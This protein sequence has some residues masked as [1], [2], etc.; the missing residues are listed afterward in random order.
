MKIGITYNL[1]DEILP[2]AILDGESM[3]EFDSPKTIDALIGVFERNGYEAVR[4]GGGIGIIDKIK[5]ESVDFVFNISEGYNGRNRESHIPSMLEAMRIPY[6]GS[7]PLTLGISLDKA[8]S[9]A[10]LSQAGIPTPAYRVAVTVDD[11][12]AIENTL[13]WPVITK[14]AWDGSSKGIYRSSKASNASELKGNVKFLLDKYPVQPVL[15][16]EYIEGRE[17]TVGVIGNNPPRILGLMEIVDKKDPGKD[18]FYSIEVKRDWKNLVDY[19]S[20]PELDTVLDNHIKHYALAAFKAFG[21]KDIARMDFR[22]SKEARPMLLEINALPG[23]SPEY[24]DIVIMSEK[25][26]I[27]H[28]ALVMNILNA[29]LSRYNLPHNT[30]DIKDGLYHEKI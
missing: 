8:V 20:P 19:I 10:I 24:S 28:D 3:E 30:K 18:F 17:V 26:G 25:I 14:P 21:C 1:K 23:L 4:L 16:E 12:R 11:I 9:K 29:A 2:E 6:S 7:D 22:I 13:S 15:V 5:S 27:P